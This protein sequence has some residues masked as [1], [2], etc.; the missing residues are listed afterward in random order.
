MAALG[1]L[2]AAV[3][4]GMRVRLE[5]RYRAVEI[6]LDG[7]DWIGL[8]R[9]E[10]RS[11]GTEL[12][13]LH[14]RGA[15]SVALSDN[16]L[17]RLADQG[18]ISYASGETL[19]STGRITTL[20]EPIR[21]LQAAGTLRSGAVYITGP[22]ENLTFVADSLRALLGS[23]RVRVLNRVVEVLGTESDLEELG[24][25]FRPS[26]AA[27]FRAAG[28]EVVLRPRNFHGL[29][30]DGLRTLVDSYA[31]TAPTPTLI[32]A[33]T[34]VQGYEGLLD[35]AA[36]E[37][38][39][40]GARFG[41]I[42]VF[43]VRRKQ[44][45]EDRLTTLMRPPA[46]DPEKFGVIRVFSVT[47]EE[48]MTLR[49]EEVADRFIRAAQ[50][51]NLRLLY[52][53]P[54]LGTPAG[55]S[56]MQ[57][58]LDLVE[59]IATNLT[60]FG[61]TPMRARPLPPLQVP[62]PLTWVVALGAAALTM[63]V[64][65]DLCRAVGLPLRPFAIPVALMLA[66]LGT[67]AAGFTR[68]DS[69]WRQLLALAVAIAGATGAAAWAL[70]RVRPG[71]SPVAQG[72]LTLIRALAA[73]V[74]AGLLVA[75]LLSQWPFMLAFR[76]FLGVKAAHILPVILVGLWLTS[77]VLTRDGADWRANA[78]RI[79][80]SI[81]QPL[82][83]GAALAA[84]FVGVVAVI[85]LARTGNIS[86]PVSGPEQQLRTTL[87]NLLVARPR[88]KEFLFGYPALVLAGASTALG[89][90]RAGIAFLLAG[91][92]GTAGAIN[93]FSHLH[94][95]FLYTAWRTGNALILGAAVALPAVLVLT[96]IARR[97]ARS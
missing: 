68:F 50:E 41:R 96:W 86:V 54:L 52:V 40:V 95:P 61:F 34:E 26:D 44:R 83:I 33:L 92:V 32:F 8:I 22:A 18:A 10:G 47:P 93:S 76:V 46:G 14:Q 66:V 19:T 5:A 24:L 51:R 74:A 17:K 35:D 72:Y 7:D 78:R 55:Q 25:G 4:L 1:V 88:T 77:E 28:F 75:A 20:T 13:A 27:P 90:R 65:V 43:T 16:T 89:W 30:P 70:A 79:L 85:L 59:T 84:V 69:L 62:A 37:Y 60:R 6:V 58:N 3:V 94:T 49:P 67:V 29:T 71:R 80:Q 63:L 57:V 38:Q 12:R 39:R 2:A 91:A 23:A 45:G 56:A 15:T 9:R 81:D 87:E 36:S 31:A 97:T 11:V 21:T 73:A 48:L 64:V 53:R 42:E 82:R